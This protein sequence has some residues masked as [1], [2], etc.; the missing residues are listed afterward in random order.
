[1]FCGMACADY[2]QSRVASCRPHGTGH[3]PHT[4]ITQNIAW[5]AYQALTT[6]WEWQPYAKTFR[7]RKIWNVLIKIHYFL[8]HLFV[9]YKR[10]YKML[11]ST[12]KA[13]A[14]CFRKCVWYRRKVNHLPMNLTG[15]KNRPVKINLTFLLRYTNCQ[16]MYL[17]CQECGA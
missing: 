15:R 4:P 14:Y 7:S 11:G 6:P 9:F 2:D 3:S 17:M 5:V 16:N 13:L 12:I 1:M 8:E 10:Y